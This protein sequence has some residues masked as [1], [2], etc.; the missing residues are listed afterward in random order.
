[1]TTNNRA[2]MK[3]AGKPTAKKTTTKKKSV[4]AKS[5]A[6]KLPSSAGKSLVIVESPAKARTVG[7]I[8]G[9]KYIVTASQGH[10]R[11]LPKS[12]IGVDVEQD[13]EPS[14]VIMKDK[15]S[16]LTQI[17]KAGKEAKEVFLATDPDRE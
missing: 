2:S 1:M 12:K 9:R 3:A 4:K 15:Q 10:I 14:Y 7:Q 16:L 8:L 6:V 5:S 13:F 17:K 11:D